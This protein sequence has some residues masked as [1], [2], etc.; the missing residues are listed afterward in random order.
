MLKK[1]IRNWCYGR[2]D[3]ERKGL[4]SLVHSL[5]RF[6]SKLGSLRYVALIPFTHL[7]EAAPY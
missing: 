7:I 6:Q 2:L 5:V 3:Q 1:V 4:V